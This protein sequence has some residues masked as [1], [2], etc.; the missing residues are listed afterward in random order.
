MVC[1]C[2]GTRLPRALPVVWTD[3]GTD[4]RTGRR[5]PMV[6]TPRV[7]WEGRGELSVTVGKEDSCSGER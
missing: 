6:E 3:E 5:Q 4:G 2:A 7:V 1:V